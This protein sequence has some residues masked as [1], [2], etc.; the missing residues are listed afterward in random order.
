[1]K[2]ILFA[3]LK[4]L[5]PFPLATNSSLFF[6]RRCLQCKDFGSV[7]RGFRLRGIVEFSIVEKYR[8]CFV[9]RVL[10]W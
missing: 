1:M 10:A 5:C 6:Y 2:N 7:I 9:H 4:F 8:Y 3:C